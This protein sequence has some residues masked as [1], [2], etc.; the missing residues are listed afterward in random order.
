MFLKMNEE[1]KKEIVN[2]LLKNN[3]LL[4]P[5]ILSD[6]LN[7]SSII[8]L[9]KEKTNNKNLLI[10][11]KDL[12]EIILKRGEKIDV[13]W[14]EFEKALVSFEKKE[15]KKIYSRFMDFLKEKPKEKE[16]KEK[17]VEVIFSYEE[18]PKKRDIQDFVALF[19]HRYKFIEN[20]LKKRHNLQNLISIKRV[21][22]MTSR[23]EVSVIGMVFDKA[24]TKNKNIL[25]TLED[26]SS[27]IKVLVNKNKPELYEKAKDI[28]FD[29]II[30]V[31]GVN[32]NNIIFANEIVWP[33]VELRDLKKS[34]K[35]EYVVFLS[36]LHVGS[37]YFLAERFNKFLEWINGNLGNEKQRE[38][39]KKV[40]YIFIIGDLIDG[41]G[42]YP[43][44]EEEIIIKDV[45]KQYDECAFL[46]SKIPKHIHLILCPGNHDA[47][48]IAEPQPKFYEDFAE[49]LYKLENAVLV[50]NPAIV[51]IGSTDSFSGFDVLLYHGYSFD[52]FVSNVD[53]IR[54][55]GG[56]D[57]A[58]L[59]M[60]F[61]LK[62][63][64]LAPTHTSTLYIP[65]SERDPLVI[66]RLP[67]FFVTGHIHKSSVANYKNITMICGSCWQSTTPFQEK[68]GHHPEPCRVPIVNLKTRNI[69]ILKF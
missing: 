57:R 48:R 33:D 20:I 59:I 21:N 23:Q 17:K 66:N 12:K 62:R 8:N 9:V 19:N 45:K 61:L 29:E 28:V 55:K 60:K 26:P 27:S 49:S 63:R 65:D 18:E 69:K 32:G 67:H 52:F 64:H 15:D 41:C 56:Y 50:S 44:Q 34:P 39:A 30:G 24:I 37:K 51:N 47:L 68:V 22:S 54:N 1:R 38:I 25:F 40:N 10:L 46:L 31:R 3:I 6:D 13:N 35:E 42:V 14:T 4:S 11:T 53:S 5:D 16:T 2:L 43:G 58:D 7:P 36:D